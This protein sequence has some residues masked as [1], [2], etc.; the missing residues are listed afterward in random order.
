LGLSDITSF[1][2][3]L[4]HRRINPP[5]A[6]EYESEYPLLSSLSFSENII[7]LLSVKK[8][9]WSRVIIWGLRWGDKSKE[10]PCIPALDCDIL[11]AKGLSMQIGQVCILDNDIRG[12]GGK[13]EKYQSNP[14]KAFDKSGSRK[15][16]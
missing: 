8:V 11:P 3:P 10:C 6:D 15:I 1:I 2:V 14:T 12:Q 4:R 13:G 9:L 7:H 16:V 5:E